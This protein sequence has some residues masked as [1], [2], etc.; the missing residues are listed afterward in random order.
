MRATRLPRWTPAS[1]PA[2][3]PRRP[4]RHW[5]TSPARGAAS[6]RS[7]PRAA[8]LAS[9]TTTPTTRPRWRPPSRPPAPR[10]RAASSRC[11]SRTCT[12]GPSAWHPSSAPR[13][14]APTWPRCSTST[15]RASAPRTSPASAGCSSPRPPPTRRAGAPSCGCRRSTMPS[16]AAWAAARRR[17]VP[18]ARCGGRGRA[19]APAGGGERQ[20]VACRQS[21]LSVA[22]AEDVVVPA[23]GFDPGRASLRGV[24]VVALPAHR[25][26]GPALGLRGA[27]FGLREAELAHEADWCG[28]SCPH[29]ATLRPAPGP[30]RRCLG[31]HQRCPTNTG[32]GT[33][34]TP[35]AACTPPAISRARATSSA[36]VPAPRLVSASVCLA[37]IAMP[38]G[39]PWPR[40]KP[41]RSM[42]HA[43]DVLTCRRPVA[44][45]AGARRGPVAARRAPATRRRRRR[46]AR[47]W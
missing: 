5:P 41:A 33:S 26:L 42:S 32:S 27:A 14:P 7:A 36:V 12:R 45:P 17:P 10:R 2:P 3:T 46:R 44:R 28:L 23:L 16:R 39:L 31:A 24:E 4:P 47:G 35:K 40:W 38:S 37:E 9:S 6:R 8:G 25:L 43:A 1:S 11:S 21:L 29:G 20:A 22:P 34:A 19:G 15:R 30:T 18:G 13:W